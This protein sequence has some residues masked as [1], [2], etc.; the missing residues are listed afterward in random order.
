LQAAKEF[1]LFQGI[2]ADQNDDTI[3]EKNRDAVFVHAKRKG[4]RCQDIAALKA[5]SIQAI[6]DKEGTG[7]HTGSSQ[8]R[9]GSLVHENPDLP[10]PKSKRSS[11]VI[12]GFAYYIP[13]LRTAL[14]RTA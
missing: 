1:L 11:R 13:N 5:R 8:R 10:K 12:S 2:Q 14:S 6:A 9:F 3:A 7:R 4:R